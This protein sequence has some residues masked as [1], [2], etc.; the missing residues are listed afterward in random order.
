MPTDRPFSKLVIWLSLASV[1]VLGMGV[2]FARDFTLDP[3][4]GR[5]DPVA[6]EKSSSAGSVLP[7]TPAIPIAGGET[8]SPSASGP[9]SSLSKVQT[10]LKGDWGSLTSNVQLAATEWSDPM[11]QWGWQRD[12]SVSIALTGPLS[13]Y[14]QL[15]ANSN[16]ASQSDLKVSGKTGLLCKMPLYGDGEIQFRSGPTFTCADP[17]HDLS[18]ARSGW[19]LEIQARYPLVWGCGLEYQGTASPALASVDRDR[20]NQDLRLAMPL[21][22]GGKVRLGARHQTVLSPADT[23]PLSLEMQLYLGV[24]L[25][26]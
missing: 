10:N 7:Q 19:L 1:L 8:T 18:Q 17:L 21:G 15:G 25:T 13:L 2:L 24:E 9:S 11:K 26:R 3:E 22:N 16:E 4:S 14:G 23:R 5:T 20:L 12:D 6:P